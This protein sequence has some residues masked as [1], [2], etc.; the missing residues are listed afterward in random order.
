MNISYGGRFRHAA[1]KMPVK[2][3]EQF[4][5]LVELLAHNPYDPRLHTKTLSG[6]LSGLYSFRLGRDYRATFQFLT[7]TEIQLIDIAHRKDIYR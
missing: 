1:K 6:K 7:E 5:V 4:A 3:K 2:Q